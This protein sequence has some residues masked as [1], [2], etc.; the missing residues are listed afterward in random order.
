MRDRRAPS[1][2]RI[3]SLRAHRVRQDRAEPL[4]LALASL[5]KELERRETTIGP[6]Q[7]AWASVMPPEIVSLSTIVS[8]SRGT[9]TV[10]I[11]DSS[12]RYATDRLLRSGLE[13]TLLKR[14]PAALRRV[15]LVP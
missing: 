3:G 14:L 2:E 6:A 11:S 5:R 8:L 9:L 10:R 7:A 15:R 4:A 12:A 1:A 13:I